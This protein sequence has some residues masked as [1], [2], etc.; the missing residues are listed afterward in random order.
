METPLTTIKETGGQQVLGRRVWKGELYFDKVTL[1]Y[2]W[3]TQEEVSDR[4]LGTWTWTQG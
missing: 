1:E 3:A 2:L 4:Q